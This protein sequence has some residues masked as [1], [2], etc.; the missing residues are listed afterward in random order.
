V[1]TGI[2]IVQVALTV[3]FVPIAVLFGLQTWRMRTVDTNLPPAEYLT[4]RL[5]MDADVDSAQ[6]ITHFERSYRSLEA[7]LESEPG[8]AGV[9]VATHVPG[10]VHDWRRFQLDLSRDTAT[11]ERGVQI[12]SVD[13]AFF[14]LMRAPVLAGRGFT[15]ADAGSGQRVV[16]VNES[17]VPALSR[18][19]EPRWPWTMAYDRRRNAGSGDDDRP[20]GA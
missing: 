8:V 5:A 12:A 9:T 10:S 16:I 7:R 17:F 3:I 18:S 19:G 11:W 2:I 1:W 6:R 4:A 14:E 13:P 20:D 15:I